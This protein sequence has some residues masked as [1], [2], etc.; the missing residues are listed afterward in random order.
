MELTK[1]SPAAVHVWPRLHTSFSSPFLIGKKMGGGGR[2][3]IKVNLEVAEWRV[4]MIKNQS[5][6]VAAIIRGG[7]EGSGRW[8]FAWLR[9]LI[10]LPADIT[11]QC[12]LEA[13]NIFTRLHVPAHTRLDTF[14]RTGGSRS[15]TVFDYINFLPSFFS[16]SVSVHICTWV[17]QVF[18]CSVAEFLIKMAESRTFVWTPA[19]HSLDYALKPPWQSSGFY[20]KAQ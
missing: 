15:E 13:L 11:E 20:V 19:L 9:V 6:G 18:Q 4:G 14:G 16:P 17:V 5:W 12:T 7:L 2:E 1:S 8:W 10:L 3:Q